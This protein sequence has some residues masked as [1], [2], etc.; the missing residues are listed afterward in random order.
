MRETRVRVAS[1]V[2]IGLVLVGAG[3]LWWAEKDAEAEL[4]QQALERMEQARQAEQRRLYRQ[5]EQARHR[6]QVGHYIPPSPHESSS[7]PTTRQQVG[8]KAGAIV[9]AHNAVKERL[10][11]PSSADFNDSWG[12]FPKDTVVFTGNNRCC[13]MGEVDAQNVFARIPHT[14][15]EG[16]RG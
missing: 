2:L 16:G 6:S 7:A 14:N 15:R 8:S 10:I 3:L 11:S 12:F 5:R 13:V 4:K 1:Y 9:A